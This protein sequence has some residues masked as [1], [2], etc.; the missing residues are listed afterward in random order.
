MTGKL[1]TSEQLHR[2]FYST[3]FTR[4]L[5]RYGY[6][7]FRRWKL[8]GDTVTLEY[9]ETPLTQYTVHYQPDKKHFRQVTDPR[10]FETPYQSS[11]GH[12]WEPGVVEWKMA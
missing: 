6:A 8:Y 3:R 10:R 5:D 4:H 12:L 9:A 7:R 1:R 2:I 11:Q